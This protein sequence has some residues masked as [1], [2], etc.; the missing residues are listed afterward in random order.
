M[1]FSFCCFFF[2]FV[3]FCRTYFC[4]SSTI[5]KVKVSNGS[6]NECD[7][8][9]VTLVLHWTGLWQV[10][11]WFVVSYG[12]QM[13]CNCTSSYKILLSETK[14][15]WSN[16]WKIARL[17][18]N[19]IELLFLFFCHRFRCPGRDTRYREPNRKQKQWG[20]IRSHRTSHN[21]T[22]KHN[23]KHYKQCYSG[24]WCSYCW[25]R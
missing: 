25:W 3:F 20:C 23:N 6:T 21:T 14:Y 1:W 24:V 22:T 19:H 8:F 16:I 15:S 18:V 10:T 11:R 4:R 13:Q 9:C 17:P 2:C 12:V 7:V 5:C